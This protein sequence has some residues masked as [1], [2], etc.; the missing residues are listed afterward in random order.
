M[1]I[2]GAHAKVIAMMTLLII[3]AWQNYKYTYQH[4]PLSENVSKNSRLDQ[5]YCVRKSHNSIHSKIF[6]GLEN[7]KQQQE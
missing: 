6:P 2:M 4:N 3:W 5:N 7:Q 1:L